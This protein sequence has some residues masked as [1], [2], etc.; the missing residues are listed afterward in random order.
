M[1][2]IPKLLFGSMLVSLLVLATEIP[3]ALPSGFLEQLPIMLEMNEDEYA[4][5]LVF[6]QSEIQQNKDGHK[7]GHNGEKTDE[8]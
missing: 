4:A 3:D 5:F 2:I 7:D 6:S 8:K 1:K